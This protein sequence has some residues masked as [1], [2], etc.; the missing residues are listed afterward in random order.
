MET[1]FG[2]RLVH[3]IQKKG[4]AACVGFDPLIERFPADLLREHGIATTEEGHIEPATAGAKITEAMVDF[5][6]AVMRAI[7]PHV[8]VVKLNIAF[9]E[10][11]HVNGIRA[12][13][14]LIRYA[15]EQGLLVI[16]DVKRAD[17]GHSTVQ[18]ARAQLGELAPWHGTGIL[19][20]DAVTV[21][22]YFGYDA[23]RPFVE[24][25]RRTGRGL[26]VL[27]QTSNESAKEI[28]D[29][30]LQDGSRVCE[31]VARLVQAWSADE[32]L[33][34]DSG[35]SC[36]G[37]VVSPRGTES[38]ARLRDLMP[39]CLLLVPGF[40]A[41]GKTVEQVRR[42][43]KADG[44]GALVTTS[45]T[46]IYAYRTPP[47]REPSDADWGECVEQACKTFART[48]RELGPS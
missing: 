24:I 28:Q 27:V 44:T 4:V 12:Y 23:I 2:D 8:P 33:V 46:V 11:Y 36:I 10:R 25:A 31:Q 16:G 43:F 42:C 47:S 18:Y 17:I 5:G 37:A 6:Q 1:H 34:G 40:G 38:T 14:E 3:A 22:P 26:F 29:L 9:F 48:V 45:R 20:A 19:N 39:N 15:R 32:D 7:A 13:G 35:Y 41:Q 30:R 21:N